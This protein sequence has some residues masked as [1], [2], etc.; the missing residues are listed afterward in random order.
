MVFETRHPRLS[1]FSKPANCLRA[2]SVPSKDLTN[3]KLIMYSTQTVR[4][5][6]TKYIINLLMVW[7]FSGK[8]SELQI[9]L[10]RYV[11][12]THTVPFTENYIL[13]F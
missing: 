1:R 12:T 9:Y 8:P 6:K 10:F 5:S 7:F 4:N 3:N 11:F 2:Y 13:P